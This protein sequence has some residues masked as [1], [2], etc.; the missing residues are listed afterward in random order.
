MTNQEKEKADL[1]EIIKT[2]SNTSD[3]EWLADALYEHLSDSISK[4]SKGHKEHGGS[5]FDRRLLSEIKAEVIDMNHYT[6][7]LETKVTT[8]IILLEEYGK[9]SDTFLPKDKRNNL[10]SIINKLKE[11]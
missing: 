6:Y 9:W 11:L 4:Y 5:I 2:V 7:A 3:A 1:L 10:G 8:I